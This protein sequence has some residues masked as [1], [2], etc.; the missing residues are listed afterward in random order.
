M[1][2]CPFCGSDIGLT[3]RFEF[4]CPVCR[5][6]VGV[7][8]DGPSPRLVRAAPDSRRAGLASYPRAH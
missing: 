2:K 4:F 1:F 7:L 6:L 5:Q 3:N 8:S